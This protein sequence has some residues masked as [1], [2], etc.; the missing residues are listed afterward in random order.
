M[1][2]QMRRV[3]LSSAACCS[4]HMR[5]AALPRVAAALASSSSFPGAG[6]PRPTLAPADIPPLLMHALSDND[7]PTTDSGLHAI[8]AFAGDTTRFIYKN[9]VTEFIE[10]AHATAEL[11][12]SFY[13]VAMNGK[14]FVMEGE[15]NLVGEPDAAWIATQIMRTVS[16]D[17]RMRRWQWE[18]RKHRRPPNLGAWYVE[19]VGSS[20]R[21]GNFDIEG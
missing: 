19:S 3:L 6:C 4:P 8:W 15:L 20:D 5:T 11:P 9:N 2:S 10:D 14:A 17:G 21:K 12:T 1:I 13:G 16:C 7:A 18:L